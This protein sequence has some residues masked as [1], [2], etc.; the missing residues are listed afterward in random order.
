MFR[1]QELSAPMPSL[2]AVTSK[3]SNATSTAAEISEE[4]QL[5]EQCE[6][7]F[8]HFNH[9]NLES[10]LRA[11]KLSLGLIRKRVFFQ[12]YVIANSI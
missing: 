9:R 1:G 3:S 6:E 7:L 5:R 12:A 8:N 10:I 2:G 4:E 11:T